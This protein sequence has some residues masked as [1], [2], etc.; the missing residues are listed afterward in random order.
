L[1]TTC[2]QRPNLAGA[3]VLVRF[4]GLGPDP[5]REF[6]AQKA[7]WAQRIAF[8]VAGEGG[9]RPFKLTGRRKR[10]GRPRWARKGRA[11]TRRRWTLQP[12]H[13]RARDRRCPS[14]AD[15][16]I[17]QSSTR[18]SQVDVIA[19]C[20][21]GESRSGPDPCT[22]G[23]RDDRKVEVT[24]LLTV[25]GEASTSL[26]TPRQSGSMV[27]RGRACGSDWSQTRRSGPRKRVAFDG[28]A[29]GSGPGTSSRWGV[30]SRK[31]DRR[32]RDRGRQRQGH[33]PRSGPIK[34]G[35]GSAARRARDH[36]PA[37]PSRLDSP[38]NW[39]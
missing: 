24:S 14:N 1:G 35:R 15:W 2:G 8:P 37:G 31:P 16:G 6:P 11:S 17:S 12:A 33:D 10:A 9:R 19:G 28:V 3:R 18:P 32:E 36:G 23:R 30:K 29:S 25:S 22:P 34:P 13:P 27:I 38:G 7:P 20:L 39:G 26:G 5:P 21:S 4:A